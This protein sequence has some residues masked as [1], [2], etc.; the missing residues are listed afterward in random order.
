MIC[1]VVV[2]FHDL[3]LCLSSQLKAASCARC[4]SE[5]PPSEQVNGRLHGLIDIVLHVARAHVKDMIAINSLGLCMDDVSNG[6]S[7]SLSLTWRS[8]SALC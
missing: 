3:M 2:C 7:L 4:S 8:R 1:V 6:D 5:M